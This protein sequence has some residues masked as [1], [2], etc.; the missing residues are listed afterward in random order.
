MLEFLTGA[1]W[2]DRIG[3]VLVHSL[4]QFAVVAVLAV[5]IQ[6][7]LHRCSAVTRYWVLLTAMSVLVVL[8]FATWFWLGPIDTPAETVALATVEPQESESWPALVDHSPPPPTGIEMLREVGPPPSRT[9]LEAAPLQE[10]QPTV[11]T[12]TRSVSLFSLVRSRVQLWLPEIVLVWLIG[13]LV[14][15]LRPLLSWYTVRRLKT[16]G[17]SPVEDAVRAALER[18]AEKLGFTRSVEVLQSALVKAPVVVGY[19]RPVILLP[20]SVLTGLPE[21]Q[22]ALILAHELAHIRRH[23]YLVNLMQTL[24]ETLFFYHPGVWWLSREIRKERE[25]C[26][27]DVAMSMVGNRADYGEALLAVAR[28]H[29]ASTPLSLAAQGGSLV[30]RMRRIAGCEPAPRLAGGGSIL[31]VLLVSLAVL[32]GVTW[33]TAPATANPERPDAPPAAE[34]SDPAAAPPA[35]PQEVWTDQELRRTLRFSFR[36]EPWADVLEWFAEEADLELVRNTP[37]PGTFNYSDA[38]EYTPKEAIDVLNS[39][40]LTHDFALIRRDKKL[41]VQDLSEAIPDGL[42]PLIEVTNLGNRGDFEL[43]T[44]RIPLGEGDATSVLAKVTA[45]KGTHGEIVPMPTTD[46][47]QITD[48]ARNVRTMVALIEGTDEAPADGAWQ[49]GQAIDIQVMNAKTKEPL[50]GVKL[51][52]QYHGPGIDFQDITTKTTDAEGRSQGR[53]PDV[54]P[55]AVR[56][57]PTKA[58]FVPLRVY[59]GDDLP[60]PKLPKSVKIRMEPGTVWG[61]VVQDEE[62]NPIP[63]VKVC[64]H[65]WETGPVSPPHIRAN[66]CV[67]DTLRTTDKDGRWQLDVMPAELDED[68]P[69]LFLTHPDYVSDHLQRGYTPTPVTERPSYEALRAQTAVMVLRKGTTIK[70]R[71]TD[72]AGK[73]ISGALVCN[74]YDAYSRHSL[75]NTATT[76]DEGRFRLSKLSHRQNYKDYFFTVQAAGYAPVFVEVREHEA[77]R[78]VEIKLKPGQTAEGQVVDEEGKPLEGVSV[79]LDYWMGR[80]RQFHLKT[81]TDA[82]GRFRI[83][84]APLERTEYDFRKTGYITVRQPLPPQTEAY[85]IALRPPVR[86]AGTIVD[87][88]TNEPLAKCRLMTGWDPDDRAPDWHVVPAKEITDGR[89]EITI[90]GEQSHTRIRVEADGYL[91]AVSRVFKPYDP[92][93]GLV[94]HDFRMKKAVSMSGTVLGLDSEPLAGAEVFLAKQQFFVEDGTASRNARRTNGMVKTDDQGQFEFPPDVEPF[95]LVVLH[96]QGHIVVD[97]KQFAKTPTVRIEP[98][99]PAKRSFLL[100]RKQINY[101]GNAPESDPQWLNV[102]I[103]DPE[104]QPVVGAKV[105]SSAGFGAEYNYLGD[106]EPAWNYFRNV[107]SDQDGRA[108]VADQYRIDSVVAWDAERKLVAIERIRPEQVQSPETVTITLQPQC[109]VFGKLTSKGLEAH[110]RKVEWSNVYVYLENGYARPM[111][112]MSRRADFH[113]YLPPGTYR[114]DAYATDTE[115]GRKTITVKPGQ[116]EL[117]VEPIDLPPKKL[118]LLEGQPAPELRGVAAWKNG[119]PVKLADLKGK[120]VVLAFTSHWVAQRP[121]AWVP[122]LF[123]ICDK[124]RDQGLEIIDIRLDNGSGIDSQAKLDEKVAEV[125]SPFW[126]DRDLP[127][128]IALGLQNRSPFLRDAKGEKVKKDLHCA[129]LKDYGISSFP[130]SVLID[131]QGRI[132]GKFNLRSD[133]DNGVLEELL[134]EE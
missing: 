79:K 8:P 69:R 55:D 89:Y 54:R 21:P 112:C 62:G 52:F 35:E 43:V 5:V 9:E 82:D 47:L 80:P 108:R 78:P 104:G 73:P 86:I 2:A 13:V 27:D 92:D 128:P 75:K 11:S 25:N 26:C 20:L 84:D 93:R 72:E 90:R 39:V 66:L 71:V 6:W 124:Y 46:Q 61:G 29:A 111:S 119:G 30:S 28:L 115:H 94:S 37:P 120:V 38:K 95:Y 15:A 102:R 76:D 106:N 113:F 65:Y 57:Y 10:F 32:V 56:I 44:V 87:A 64:V 107:P 129:T 67:G 45:A 14:A 41:I 100:Q 53:L 101:G 99:Q 132:V 131:R 42:V 133:R 50:P 125:K 130:S 110:N 1:V 3:W 33:D 36:F 22:L 16:V 70:G 77:A 24:V 114:L 40:L 134:K 122:N 123:T 103:V 4:W 121:H 19:F 17:V 88:E 68:G 85:R 98:W 127:I 18:A 31:G 49:P 59:W 60:S 63:D 58:G 116:Q 126:E 109:R 74:Q 23:D 34:A 96:E 12:P 118:V 81:T 91:P 7:A 48:T 51:E 117:E 105:A 97:E 83:D